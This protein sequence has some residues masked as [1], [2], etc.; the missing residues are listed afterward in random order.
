M[1]RSHDHRVPASGRALHGLVFP[2]LCLLAAWTISCGRSHDP[3]LIRASGHIEMT[4]VRLSA[5]VGGR[6]VSFPLREGDR[7]DRGQEIALIDSTDLVLQRNVVRADLEQATA[8]LKLRLAGSRADEIAE[9]EALLARSQAELDAAER[10]LGRMEGLL[11]DGSGTAKARDDARNRRDQAAANLEAVRQQL[12]RRRTGSRPE[13]IEAARAR[14]SAAQARLAQ[15]EQQLRDT[16]LLSPLPGLVT[17]KVAEEGELLSPGSAV[18]VI[19]D[20]AHPWLTVYVGEP[21]LGRVR[22]GGEAEVLT[23]GGQKRTGRISFI[24][25]KAEFTPKN[26]QTQDERVKL[27]YKVKI[28]LE[29]EDGLFKSGMPAETRIR[30]TR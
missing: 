23:D 7:V 10:D 11:R 4:E 2:F 30:G 17:E 5:K 25:E 12:H 16:H 8:E 18:C 3:G 20:L 22:L 28:A 15:V 9:A 24:A 26:V 1:K 19:T 6:L 14:Q 21:D 27:V 29:N 13:E